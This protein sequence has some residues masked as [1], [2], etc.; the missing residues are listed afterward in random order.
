MA[1]QNF[2]KILFIFESFSE[3]TLGLQTN[4]E[5]NRKLNSLFPSFPF[6]WG[7]D[8]R[9]CDLGSLTQIYMEILVHDKIILQQRASMEPLIYWHWGVAEAVSS[10]VLATIF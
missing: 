2:L 8:M 6:P 9:S 1:T 4:K 7:A 5:K 10:L 3:Y